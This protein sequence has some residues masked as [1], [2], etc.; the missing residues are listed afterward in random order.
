MYF[1]LQQC[2]ASKPEILSL[3][4]TGSVLMCS[5]A[6]SNRGR[7]SGNSANSTVQESYGMLR[8]HFFRMFTFAGNHVQKK[9]HL[10]SLSIFRS[11][12]LGLAC[13]FPVLLDFMGKIRSHSNPDGLNHQVAKNVTGGS[14]PLGS[15]PAFGPIRTG[16]GSLGLRSFFIMER[17]G[18][19]CCK[20][21]AWF[22][23]NHQ[24][25][26]ILQHGY[27]PCSLNA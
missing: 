25:F 3:Q 19:D 22:S 7:W 1:A 12:V 6:T 20:L 8:L 21:V 26:L 9:K 10:S 13:F 24:F 16:D 2:D 23:Q 11:Y 17:L 15:R 4:V 5:P 14:Q 18:I 27:N